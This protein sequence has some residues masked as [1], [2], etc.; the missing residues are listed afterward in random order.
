MVLARWPNLDSTT[1]KQSWQKIKIG[2]AN[3]FTVQDPTAVAHMA[4]WGAETEP[5]LHSYPLFAW[6]DD[7]NHFNVSASA[8]EVNVTVTD[9]VRGGAQADVASSTVGGVVGSSDT[10]VWVIKI[11]APSGYSKPTVFCNALGNVFG[12]AFGT[13]LGNTAHQNQQRRPNHDLPRT[14]ACIYTYKHT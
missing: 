6:E 10:G 3:G 12:N 14:Y 11:T 2:G 5:W 4:K 8:T 1:G 9:P 7:W 13:A